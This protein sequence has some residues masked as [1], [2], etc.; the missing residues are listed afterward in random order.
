MSKCR[1][2]VISV[3]LLRV[4]TL[5]FAKFL[6]ESLDWRL[7]FE[8][9]RWIGFCWLTAGF[10][11]CYIV[12]LDACLLIYFMGGLGGMIGFSFSLYY[13]FVKTLLVTNFFS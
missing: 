11:Y 3:V 8:A 5:L 4:E 1:L 10:F 12:F 2:G 7:R 13:L 9:L 6:R